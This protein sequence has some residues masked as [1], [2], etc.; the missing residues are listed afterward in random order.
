MVYATSVLFECTKVQYRSG[1]RDA[2]FRIMG[3]VIRQ[4]NQMISHPTPATHKQELLTSLTVNHIM[5]YEI[6]KNKIE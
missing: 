6:H 2:T 5:S 1:N 3:S 4:S